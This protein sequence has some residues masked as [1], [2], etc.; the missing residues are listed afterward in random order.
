MTLFDI[1]Y[2]KLKVL[3]LVWGAIMYYNRKKTI[4]KNA[5]FIIAIFA[6]AIIATYK[7]Y[8]HFA[9]STDID[10]NSESL[11]ITFHEKEGAKVSLTKAIPVSDSVGL[12]SS[13]YTFTI[14]NNLTEPVNY[15]IKLTEDL[16]AIIEDLCIEKQIP[17]E[18]LRVSIKEN[19]E[20]N[21]IYTLSELENAILKTDI[22]E[23][24]EEIDYSVRIWLNNSGAMHI[25]SDL[26]YHGMIQ[27]IENGEHLA[28]R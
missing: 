4:I 14:K 18:Q 20:K 16:D 7:I 23:A 21:E 1:D 19:N 17:K 9:G 6:L 12:S 13:A 11:D 5:T 25:G 27:V 26:H 3:S 8:Y 10:Y 28:V 22:M 15:Q 2:I 24:L